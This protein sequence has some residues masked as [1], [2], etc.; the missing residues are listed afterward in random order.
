MKWLII[1]LAL[2]GAPLLAQQPVLHLKM[3][4]EGGTV[5]SDQSRQGNDAQITGDLAFIPDRFGNACRALRFGGQGYLRVPHARSLNLDETF[6]VSVWAKLPYGLRAWGLQWLTIVCKGETPT[7]SLRSPAFRAQLTSA[8]ASINTASTKSIGDIRLAFPTDRW[9]HVVLV[10]SGQKL[11]LYLDGQEVAR[12]A[13]KDPVGTNREPLNVGRDIPGNVEYYQG[14]MDELKLYDVALDAKQVARLYRDSSDQ[15]LGS[16]CPAEPV[17][18]P[19]PPASAPKPAPAPPPRT[20]PFAQMKPRKEPE[21]EPPLVSEPA[22]E[23]QAPTGA[24]P[25]RAD[26]TE[27]TPDPVDPYAFTG[28]AEN[29]LTLLLDVSGSMKARDKLPLLKDAFLEL[30]THMRPEDRISVVTYAG[31]VD[32]VLKG[33][34]ASQPERIAKAI[35]E[36]DSSGK[37]NGKQG[38]RRAY[39]VARNNFIH[40]GNNRVILATDG[41]FDL[42]DLY[43]LAEN[44]AEDE[45]ALSVFSFGQSNRFKQAYMDNLAR[46][47]QGN[48]ARINRSNV[49]QALLREVK[50][51]KKGE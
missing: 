22:P 12:Y 37:T 20:P 13:L 9:F 4:R 1:A 27:P 34:S 30:L 10:Y 39:R 47:G 50:A 49:E 29:N 5:V 11:T 15:G 25:P 24:R 45:I 44:M 43:R 18:S 31:G 51:V 42:S 40:R 46:K 2:G 48:H 14:D 35:E 38:L 19:S 7:E 26:P 8:T 17:A 3:D 36:L 16:A 32:V 28:Y 23:P 33:V 41:N 6:S 21:P